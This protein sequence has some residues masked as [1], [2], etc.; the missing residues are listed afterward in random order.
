MKSII[1]IF[2]VLSCLFL[3]ISMNSAIR[4][5]VSGS[6]RNPLT[7]IHPGKS[8]GNYTQRDYASWIDYNHGRWFT[9]FHLALPL[10]PW[11]DVADKMANSAFR[12]LVLGNKADRDYFLE[13]QMAL[14]NASFKDIF[15]GKNF[16]GGNNA[17]PHGDRVA[18]DLAEVYLAMRHT[19]TPEQRIKV[20]KWYHEFA[21]YTWDNSNYAIRQGT[22]AGFLAV[23]GYMTSDTIMIRKAKEYLS[24]ENTWTI[25]ED[26]RHYAGLIMERMFRIE[27]FTNNFSF[28]QSSKANLAKQMR[29]I[30]SI[31]PHNGFNPPWGDC[32]I[33]NEIDH[34]MECLIMASHFLKDYDKELA[35]ECKWLSERMFEYGKKHFPETGGTKNN[36]KVINYSIYDLAT[37]ESSIYKIQANPIHFLWYLDEN[38]DT[39]KP[40][41]ISYGSKVVHRLRALK[42]MKD[43]DTSLVSF[44][45]KMDKI[46]HR[47]SWDKDA[48]FVMLDPVL[49]SSKNHEGGA[50]NAIISISYADEEFLTGK[51]SPR[52]N[53]EYIQNCVADIPSDPRFN[54]GTVLDCFTENPDYSRS[55][56]TL[57]GWKRTVTLYKTNDR[58]IEVEDYLPRA[59]N[60]YWHLQGIPG[61][62]SDKVTLNVRGT[63]M[64][65]SYNGHDRSSHQ[66]N[67]TWNDTNP[68][69]R[70]GYT[71]NPDRQ[72]KLYRSTPGTIVT[73]FRPININ[74]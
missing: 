4:S 25:Q 23:V 3:L 59:G 26:S 1:R 57:E 18:Q 46:I 61:W 68:L 12:Y 21:Q 20:E 29:W 2:F 73:T 47:D 67:D 55:V 62:G 41:I 22:K 27:I 48:L 60:V 54:Y 19:M 34:Y 35:Q 71:G 65:V 74:K 70:W 36:Q 8:Q 10:H 11:G 24:F 9:I 16:V 30:I 58:R 28:P 6:N 31:F 69:L 40:D 42:D 43:T 38:L 13:N 33:P 5:N 37:Q 44:E 66:D 45:D 14:V 53:K 51:I 39:K 50:G 7:D 15:L 63:K 17:H 52:F 49:H 64:A 32:W 72:L 56:T